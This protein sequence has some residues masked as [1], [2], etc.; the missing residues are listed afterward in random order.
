MKKGLSRKFWAAMLV[1]GL[2]GLVAWVVEN[3]SFHVSLDKMFHASTA[4]IVT[5]LVLCGGLY[6]IF[7]MM[8]NEHYDLLSETGEEFIAEI[9]RIK[10]SLQT[11]IMEKI[12][13]S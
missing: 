6:L 2:V 7:F 13:L 12:P 1:F 3:M 11:G 9:V 10:S 5:G 8:R 4:V